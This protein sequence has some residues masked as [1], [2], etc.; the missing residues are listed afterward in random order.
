MYPIGWFSIKQ[1]LADCGFDAKI[2]NVA[3]IRGVSSTARFQDSYWRSLA[4]SLGTCRRL[5]PHV[6][7]A[8]YTDMLGLPIV[9]GVALEDLFPDL[10]ID[11]R[12]LPWRHASVLDVY[13]EEAE[14]LEH[15]RT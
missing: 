2:V 11:V 14:R 13:R 12:V 7:L 1:R 4:V 6:Q 9:D 8:V 15:R 10:A 5:N 3:Q